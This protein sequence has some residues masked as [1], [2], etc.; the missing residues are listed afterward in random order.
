MN[1]R[2]DG[3]QSMWT[4]VLTMTQQATAVFDVMS[5]PCSALIQ[6]AELTS[7]TQIKQNQLKQEPTCLGTDNARENL[8]PRDGSQINVQAPGSWWHPLCQYDW[9]NLTALV[10]KFVHRSNWLP[11]KILN[12]L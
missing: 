3:F 2:I 10:G 11:L 6:Y 1:G 8:A 4:P 7:Q 5:A 9:F 12:Y